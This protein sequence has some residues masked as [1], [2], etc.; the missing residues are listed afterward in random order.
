M[1]SWKDNPVVYLISKS[2]R[3][4]EGNRKAVAWFYILFIL[5]NSIKILEPLVIAKILNV[6]QEEGINQ[7]NLWSILIYL[8]IF[9][10][11]T[12]GFW[13]FQGPARVMEEKNSFLVRA[14]Y[15][16]YLLDGVMYLKPEW[17]SEN[18]SGNTIDKIEKATN[19]LFRFSN[20]I[21]DVVE[22]IVLFIGSYI[23][24]MYFN[25]HASYIVLLTVI[26][27]V[28]M[29]LRFDKVLLGQYKELFRAE[30]RISA[31]IY[32]IIGNIT[33]V[34]ILRI[35]KLVGKAIFKKIM[36][37]YEL[38]I[39][40]NKLNEWKWFFVSFTGSVMMVMVIATFIYFEF[41]KGSVILI[42]T[43]FALYS[44]VDR[45]HGLF[46]RFTH[47]YGDFVRKKAAVFN[48]QEIAENFEDIEHV[49]ST[50]LKGKW[51]ELRI[52]NLNF[53]YHKSIRGDLHLDNVT[54][55]IKRKQ[56]I[57]LIGSSGSGKTT[58]LKVIRDLY[59]PRRLD[60]SLDGKKL[61]GG[62]EDISSEIALI[63]QDP[64]IFSTTIKDNITL[65]VYHKIDYI[66][67]FTDMARFSSVVVKLPKKLNSSINEKG[68]NLSGGQK[69]R[70]ALARGLMACVDKELILLDE[71]TSSV[72]FKNELTIYKNIFKEFKDKTI[73]SSIHKLHLLKMFDVIYLFEDGKIKAN[74]SFN[75]M[76]KKSWHFRKM[77]EKYDKTMR[78]KK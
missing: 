53:S 20:E 69:Q 7:G 8:L 43:I 62:F 46:F 63:P 13:V 38:F 44:Y 56:K 27:T 73:L 67:K 18:H 74:G 22:T 39:K 54:L 9:I 77:W 33:T 21:S 58:M 68:V 47:K 76:M 19:S 49:K 5:A 24:L 23:A 40:T 60:L 36:A 10:G 4:S 1:M 17:H 52:E 11:L 30:N 59:H 15:K 57:A 29:I 2:W 35:E 26:V 75:E 50:H 25:L 66:R 16:K 12:L 42:G 14:N 28:W 61:E 6:I 70:L 72:D 34:T 64:E 31:K 71:P 45:I 65:G 51:K 48:A 55:S 3:F 32:D 41:Q 78:D 37:P